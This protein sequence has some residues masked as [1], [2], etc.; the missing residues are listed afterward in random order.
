MDQLSTVNVLNQ[1]FGAGWAMYNGDSVEVIKGIPDNS[2]GLQVFS[3]PFP[4]MYAYTNSAHDMGNTKNFDEMM[5]QFGY[6]MPELLR[7]LMPGR[8]CAVHL[9]QTMASKV[10]DGYMGIKDF[11]G[12]TIKAM[13]AHGFIYYGEVCIDKCPQLKAIRTKDHG[14]MFK[15]LATDASRM[16]MAL[17]DYI[18]QFRKPGDNPEPIK[19]GISQKYANPDGWITDEEW[20]EW[21]APVWYRATAHY[22]GGIRETDVLNVSQARE[23]DDERHLCPLQL[24]VIERCVKL[25]SNP[26]DVVLSP[27]G[28]IGSEGYQS[29]LHNRRFVGIELK[30]SYWRQAVR[31]LRAAESQKSQ[32]TLF[33]DVVTA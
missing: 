17:A 28:G 9:T 6:L 1:E 2:V 20:I 30:E 22:P 15:S 4:G 26:G 11:R 25:W 27:F 13:E 19:A 8:S 29:L 16:H 32:P 10:R 31:N 18:L 7:V 14:L 12:A 24:G 3:P 5:T 21:A 23:T 33:D